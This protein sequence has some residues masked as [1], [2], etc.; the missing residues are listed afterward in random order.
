MAL[1]IASQK[2]GMLILV[3]RTKAKIEA[4]ANQIAVSFPDVLVRTVLVDLGSQKSIRQAAQEV[5]GIASKIDI[6]IN[7]AAVM[8]PERHVTEDGIEQQFGTNHIG[9]FLFTN[10]LMD[11][12]KAAAKNN[13]PGST[14]IVNV[15]SAG[16]RISPIRFND[17]NFEGKPL[18]QDEEPT[19]GLP[20]SF[21]VPGQTYSGFL[22]YGQCKTANT[23]LSRNLNDET[24]KVIDKTGDF[25]KSQDQG[26]ATMLVAAFDPALN[27]PSGHYLSDCQIVSPAP[28]ASDP[29]VADRLWHLSEELVGQTFGL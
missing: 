13:T 26:A 7:N 10:L 14:R 15:T 1:S 21:F 16:H 11:Q 22:A 6:L 28:H 25:W 23:D 29:K 3:S 4:V 2:P 20:P 24:R 8:V 12:I 27:K 17:Y 5:A 18:P 19:S 9:P